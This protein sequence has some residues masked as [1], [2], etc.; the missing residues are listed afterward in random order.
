M[1]FLVLSAASPCYVVG[2]VGIG[3]VPGI[4]EN[5]GKVTEADIAPIL[6]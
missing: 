4:K 3:H 1:H 6:R 5:W 2:V